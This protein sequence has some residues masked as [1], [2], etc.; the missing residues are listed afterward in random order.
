MESA[1]RRNSD[2]FNNKCRGLKMH[3]V[4]L[5]RLPRLPRARVVG[6]VKAVVVAKVTAT[7]VDKE[8]R[9]LV[10]QRAARE[11]RKHQ[12]SKEVTDLGKETVKKG[13]VKGKATVEWPGQRNL[14]LHFIAG[15]CHF[16][17]TCGYTHAHP[18]SH[19]GRECYDGLRSRL[20]SRSA[21]RGRG[22]SPSAGANVER[23]WWK[24]GTCR[25]GDKCAFVH[26]NPAPAALAN[27]AA[28][29]TSGQG[30]GGQVQQL[31][32]IHI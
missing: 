17:N 5:P 32:L 16:G 1:R 30:S 21:P 28:G 22:R 24:R 31:S 27:L 12:L 7:V 18:T 10:T 19:E 6:V 20:K 11:T 23:I 14:R 4:P 8:A 25:M 3:A 13:S 26:S 29:L 15:N 2:S 9:L